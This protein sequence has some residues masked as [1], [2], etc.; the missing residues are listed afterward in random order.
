MVRSLLECFLPKHAAG[1]DLSRLERAPDSFSESAALRRRADRIWRAGVKGDPQATV[2]AC[3]EFQSGVDRQ[4][5]HRMAVYANLC[6]I[7]AARRSW[8]K[9]PRRVAALPVVVY[10]GARP[11]TA[12]RTGLPRWD[13]TWRRDPMVAYELVDLARQPEYAPAGREPAQALARAFPDGGHDPLRDAFRRWIGALLA[14]HGVK[15][16]ELTILLKD[17][18]MLDETMKGWTEQWLAEGREQGLEQ[19]LE[20]GREQGLE[21]GLERGRAQTVSELKEALRCVVEGLFGAEVAGEFARRI[22]PVADSRRLRVV[23]ARVGASRNGEELL[24]NCG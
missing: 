5:A 6:A 20:Q 4:M 23:A 13:G 24:R 15:A 1:L 18:S 12:P 10:N 14:K 3:L 9:P 16:A 7:E 8:G 17:E 19:G 21:Q 22:E 2:L 11:W